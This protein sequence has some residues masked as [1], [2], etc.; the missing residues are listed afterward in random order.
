M[1]E[2]FLTWLKRPYADDMSAGGW[3]LFLG[4]LIVLSVL[5]GIIL[6]HI[7]DAT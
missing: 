6:R 2:R 5:W 1:R 4:L 3:F 7:K